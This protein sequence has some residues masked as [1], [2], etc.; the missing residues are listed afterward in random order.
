MTLELYEK[1]FCIPRHMRL[2]SVGS[3]LWSTII[4]YSTGTEAIFHTND[5]IQRLKERVVSPQSCKWMI[6]WK[7]Y[8]QTSQAWSKA[9]CFYWNSLRCWASQTIESSGCGWQVSSFGR[10]RNFRGV[11]SQG[12]LHPSGYRYVGISGLNFPVHRVVMIAFHGLPKVQNESLVHHRDRN[13]SNN[14]LDNLEWASH[15]QNAAYYYQTLTEKISR[16]SM[17]KPVAWRK[18]GAKMWEV[19]ASV[20]LAAEQLGISSAV[21]SECCRGLSSVRGLEIHFADV[22]LRPLDGEEWR[23]M[24]DPIS[25]SE[26]PGRHVSSLGR[27]TSQ[28]GCMYPGSLSTMGYYATQIFGH[29]HLVHRLVALSFLGRP[30]ADRPFVNHK[31]LDKG[32]NAVENLEYVSLT[33]NQQHFHANAVRK[34]P[35]HVKPVWSRRVGSNGDWTWHSS[36]QSASRALG[37]FS[38]SVSDCVQGRQK[39]TGGYEFRL[40]EPPEAATLPGEEW[41]MV[42]LGQL[43]LDRRRRME[44]NM[45]FREAALPG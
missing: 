29:K 3:S 31:D 11:V 1:M 17:R 39:Q 36:M 19:C 2:K 10:C 16:P 20:S 5:R 23:P 32:N 33:E 4:H 21:V 9:P 37:V 38:A 12:S 35:S 7:I 6:H 45:T 44:R 40:A 27:I 34:G 26:V 43:Q 30:P 8:Q 15:S 18:L 41:R 24:L 14:H 28:K 42:D 13:K 25:F 22:G